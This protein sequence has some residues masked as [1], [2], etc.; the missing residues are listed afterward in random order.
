MSWASSQTGG[1]RKAIS[2]YPETP[3]RWHIAWIRS[4][5]QDCW[6]HIYI[7]S[8]QGCIG[9]TTV[10]VMLHSKGCVTRRSDSRSFPNRSWYAED[11]LC[12]VLLEAE[13]WGIYTLWCCCATLITETSPG[14]CM[15][16]SVQL[17]R[18]SD[19]RSGIFL[20]KPTDCATTQGLCENL[21]TFALRENLW[22]VSPSWDSVNTAADCVTL[23]K[24]VDYA[25]VWGLLKKNQASHFGF[26][27]GVA[28]CWG[29]SGVI[30]KA[31]T[32]PM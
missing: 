8:K 18:V 9:V 4:E 7:Q 27:R 32:I 12:L 10:K 30:S 3:Q 16:T 25:T 14:L 1:K 22:C 17:F 31:V 23:W 11:V 21:L 15:T 5:E 26:S 13:H 2:P 29:A 19:G 20:W 24:I 6:G 28:S